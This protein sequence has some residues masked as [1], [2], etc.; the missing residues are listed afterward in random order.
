MTHNFLT[1]VLVILPYFLVSGVLL[2]VSAWIVNH[3][4]VD[5]ISNTS[6]VNQVGHITTEQKHYRQSA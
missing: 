6:N 1:V 3:F 4:W 5:P 2:G